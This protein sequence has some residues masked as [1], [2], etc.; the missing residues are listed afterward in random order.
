MLPG[1]P[2]DDIALRKR[3]API[4]G[5]LV[6]FPYAPSFGDTVLTISFEALFSIALRETGGRTL[7][8]GDD[9]RRGI[10]PVRRQIA[11]HQLSPHS[12][13][14]HSR[15]GS[16]GAFTTTKRLTGDIRPPPMPSEGGHISSAVEDWR[17]SPHQGTAIALHHAPHARE[18]FISDPALT[19]VQSTVELRK[20]RLHL[21]ERT[22]T[23]LHCGDMHIQPLHGI[24]GLQRR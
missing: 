10:G 18:H 13:V 17:P 12:M 16:L 24:L 22:E 7:K 14:L 8:R 11:S 23:R 20:C 2:L 6:C 21:L 5:A 19:L 3:H 4:L 1:E 15:K 9:V